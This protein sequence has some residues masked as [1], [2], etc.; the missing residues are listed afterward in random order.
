MEVKLRNCRRR[1]L[2]GTDAY[3]PQTAAENVFIR[4]ATDQCGQALLHSGELRRVSDILR[5]VIDQSASPD[6]V[7][8]N[9]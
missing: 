4:C 7:L 9:K 6:R 8:V 2:V 3:H 5:P 1:Q